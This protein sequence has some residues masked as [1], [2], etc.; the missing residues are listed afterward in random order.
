[1]S[2]S[3]STLVFTNTRS[4]SEL[5]YQL[6]L[7]A[8]PDLAGQLAL[9]HG[10][11]DHAL[12]QWIE[13]ALSSGQLKAVVC[14]SSLDLGV[15]FKTVDTVVQIGSSKGIARFLQRAGRSGHS[16]Y[17]TSKIYFVP[18]H[19]LE[20]LE[21]AALKDAY[22]NKVVEKR[23]P[24]VLC[25]DVLVQFMVTIA[26]GGGFKSN[27]LFPIIQQTHAFK[28]LQEEDWNWCLAFITKG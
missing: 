22:K 3:R 24:M 14:T 11:I 21:V 16:P 18:T 10:S 12:R 25:Y 13:N 9:H 2:S 19:T 7:N 20:L 26:L 8:D 17:E 4:Q 23:E 28:Y 6:L 15:D 1:I 5:W 27:E